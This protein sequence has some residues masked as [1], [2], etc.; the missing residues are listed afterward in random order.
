MIIFSCGLLY[1]Q[2]KKIKVSRVIDGDTFNC[3]WNGTNRSCRIA[4]ID[5]PELKQHFGIQAYQ[6]LANLVYGKI[7]LVDSISTDR[8]KRL[9][10]FV[11]LENRRLDQFLVRQGYAWFYSDYSND[12]GIA[13]AMSRAVSQKLGL[14]SCGKE[15]VCPPWL[16]R[17]YDYR[18]KYRFC[19]GC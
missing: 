18:N 2:S 19:K 15:K 13:T 7:I 17:H 6:K 12:P 11:R 3:D 1:G 5:A 8:Y 10:V 4:N 14:W 9:I 16:F